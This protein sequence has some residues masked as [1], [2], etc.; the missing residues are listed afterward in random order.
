M[1]AIL[2]KCA[3]RALSTR[4]HVLK[5][6][7]KNTVRLLSSDVSYL[8]PSPLPTHAGKKT[9]NGRAVVGLFSVNITRMWQSATGSHSVKELSLQLHFWEAEIYI[10]KSSPQR[11]ITVIL[12]TAFIHNYHFYLHLHFPF[13]R[14]FM[15]GVGT[16]Q[17][18][19]LERRHYWDHRA[20][21]E[22]DS[23]LLFSRSLLEALI[24]QRAPH[25]PKQLTF[26]TF[27]RQPF[28]NSNTPAPFLCQYKLISGVIDM[29][30]YFKRKYFKW[31]RK[32]R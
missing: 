22:N 12:P 26:P 15:L 24:Q 3:Q 30:I 18:A 6:G 7:C 23:P 19:T 16:L 4:K 21:K 32:N 1:P 2:L 27:L 17:H 10:Y 14:L 25:G 9:L 31:L 20:A 28:L 11:N 29:W 8:T 13:C 5:R